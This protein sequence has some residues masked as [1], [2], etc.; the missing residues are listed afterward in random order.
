MK[1]FYL[2]DS[3]LNRDFRPA[4]TDIH[5]L[6]DL[7]NFIKASEKK[8][9]KLQQKAKDNTNE[10]AQEKIMLEASKQLEETLEGLILFF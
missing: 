6:K 4:M 2:Q 8:L 10:A 7:K 3:G 9:K 5:R 1:S